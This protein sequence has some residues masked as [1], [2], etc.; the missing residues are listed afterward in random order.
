MSAVLAQFKCAPECA[1][2]LLNLALPSSAPIP[3]APSRATPAEAPAKEQAVE[4]KNETPAAP[5]APATISLTPE[6]LQAM[7]DKAAKGAVAASTTVTRDP[8]AGLVDAASRTTSTAQAPAVITGRSL[9]CPS[10]LLRREQNSDE[11]AKSDVERKGLP[12]ARVCA[13]VLTS[14][15]AR[16]G[17]AFRP[18]EKRERLCDSLDA[19]GFR[20]TA[21]KVNNAFRPQNVLTEGAADAGGS[22]VPT[23]I[24]QGFVDT[25][26][27]SVVIRPV[28]GNVV[29]STRSQI[30]W[31]SFTSSVSGAWVGEN[32]STGN[33]ETPATGSFSIE[34]KKS[35]V[36]IVIS[37]DLLRDAS[38]NM[39]KI[40]RGKLVRASALLEDLALVQGSGAAGQPK[41]IAASGTSC[42][43]AATSSLHLDA[44]ADI[45]KLLSA[46]EIGRAHV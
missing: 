37:R 24:Q 42:A 11:S 35:R 16:P 19:L 32:P 7:L 46:L 17:A 25:L 38:V 9:K 5:V 13:A 12:M 40:V 33:P 45:I 10:H 22:F 18:D 29:S 1:A 31:P 15:I 34:A 4:P 41:G 27:D 8:S 39:D 14:G 3:A 36:E 2:R 28:F 43:T 30:Q 21:E 20:A 26:E 23:D 44:H 6:Q